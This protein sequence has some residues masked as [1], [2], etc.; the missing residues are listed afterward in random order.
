M[1]LPRYKWRG[2]SVEL[3]EGSFLRRR[4]KK[5][6]FTLKFHEK[7]AIIIVRFARRNKTL[8]YPWQFIDAKAINKNEGALFRSSRGLPERYPPV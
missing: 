3:P 5:E 1:N 8:P 4:I 7:S 6:K 2:F